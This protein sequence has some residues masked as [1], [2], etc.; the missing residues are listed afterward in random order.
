M[1]LR[2]GGNKGGKK[3]RASGFCLSVRHELLYL[4][5]PYVVVVRES[6]PRES[7]SVNSKVWK[8]HIENKERKKKL[9]LSEIPRY[10]N[11]VFGLVPHRSETAATVIQQPRE[12]KKRNTFFCV[13]LLHYKGGLSKCVRLTRALYLF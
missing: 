2:G 10:I 3:R 7:R 9:Q 8:T 13:L 5:V 4:T 11:L 12:R 1:C 6:V